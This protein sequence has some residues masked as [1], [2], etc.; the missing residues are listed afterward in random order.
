MRILITAAT[1]AELLPAREVWEVIRN[2]TD[3]RLSIECVETGIGATATA[4][5]TLKAL[6][7]P[8]KKTLSSPF[9]KASSP[10]FEKAPSPPFEKASSPPFE[11][12]LSPPF[13]VAV[14]MGIA[15]SFC[16]ALPIGAVVRITSEC[17]G[18]LG[19]QTAAGFQSLFDAK[20]LDADR[21]PFKSG[22]LAPPP[23]SPEW[24]SALASVPVAD[25]VTVQRLVERN[26][27]AL[28]PDPFTVAER[29]NRENLEIETMEGAAFFYVCMSE[30][31]PC[32]SLR[33]VSNVAGE[34]DKTKWNI[35]LALG[36]L[37][38]T[39]RKCLEAR[40]IEN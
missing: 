19:V 30:H 20:L 7:P 15:G 32:F 27:A 33:A 4:Y 16:N 28:H 37:L 2:Q 5:H 17:F 26:G 29:I 3:N 6:L 1:A 38:Q 12:A 34:Q 39:F 36:N 25:G 9:E 31:I 21:F 35:P 18:D 11:K 8:S 14:N 10:P 13:D 22:K 24:E 23:L 40:L